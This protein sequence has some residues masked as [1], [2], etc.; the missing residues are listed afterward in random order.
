MSSGAAHS[1]IC[2]VERIFRRSAAWLYA[3]DPRPTETHMMPPP[4]YI[5]MH[6]NANLSGQDLEVL[7]GWCSRTA[8]EQRSGKFVDF[9]I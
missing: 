4:N 1:W 5:W 6:S 3:G 9:N 7:K 8:K 2:L